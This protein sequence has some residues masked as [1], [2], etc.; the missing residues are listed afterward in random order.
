MKLFKAGMDEENLISTIQEAP[1]T[2]F[3]MSSALLFAVIT[4]SALAHESCGM[5]KDL[6]VRALERIKP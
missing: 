3:D 6:M 1:S 4:L 2:H 5:A